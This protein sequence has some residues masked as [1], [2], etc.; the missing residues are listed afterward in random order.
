MKKLIIPTEI[1]ICATCSYWDGDRRVD[2][3]WQ[4]VVVEEDCQGECLAQARPSP[5]LNDLRQSDRSAECIWE[6]LAPD[7]PVAEA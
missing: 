6:H 3:E 4:L 1:K 7:P 5:A 2:S